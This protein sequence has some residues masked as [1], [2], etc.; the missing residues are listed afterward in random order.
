MMKK[1]FFFKQ[2]IFL[3]QEFSLKFYQNS[4]NDTI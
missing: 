4:R 1:M 3:K 2:A